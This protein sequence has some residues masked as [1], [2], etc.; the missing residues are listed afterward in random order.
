V[1]SH[2]TEIIGGEKL[3]IIQKI[4]PAREA[5]SDYALEETIL[6]VGGIDVDLA[7]EQ[8]DQEVVITFSDHSGMIHRGMMPCCKYVAEVIIPPRQYKT[9]EVEGPPSGMGASGKGAG[10]DE[11]S[12]THMETVPEPL[13]LDSVVLNIWPVDRLEETIITGEANAD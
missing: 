1:E 3:M 10:K 8:A 13:D 5:F 7:A 9:V 12:A 11:V 2:K 4:D 6:T